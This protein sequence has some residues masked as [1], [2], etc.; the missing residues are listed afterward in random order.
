[1][2]DTSVFDAA[3]AGIPDD[4]LYVRYNE[5]GGITRSH[6][7]ADIRK[8]NGMNGWQAVYSAESDAVFCFRLGDRTTGHTLHRRK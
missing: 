5:F 6:T 7:M 4:A 1:M 3:T 2:L 8:L